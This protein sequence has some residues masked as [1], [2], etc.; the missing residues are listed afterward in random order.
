MVQCVERTSCIL[1]VNS[2]LL[3]V[4]WPSRTRSINSSS[5][6]ANA[7]LPGAD[8]S[9][10]SCNFCSDGSPNSLNRPH[11]VSLPSVKDDVGL[12]SSLGIFWRCFEEGLKNVFSMFLGDRAESLML[13]GLH[14]GRVLILSTRTADTPVM[15]SSVTRLE[16]CLLV[17][18]IR[19]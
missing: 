7:P 10:I 6:S 2:C 8:P 16:P 12:K 3:S 11:V 14:S 9:T 1:L 15:K 13:F 5:L 18:I 19:V 17:V 4:G